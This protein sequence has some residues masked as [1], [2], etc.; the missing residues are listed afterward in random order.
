MRSTNV[1]TDNSNFLFVLTGSVLF[2]A[3]LGCVLAN[4]L[5]A[6]PQVSYSVMATVLGITSLSM[7][8]KVIR[9]DRIRLRQ[10]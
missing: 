3:A 6:S 1:T 2:I 9:N 7:L 5:V 4:L 10:L 8:Y